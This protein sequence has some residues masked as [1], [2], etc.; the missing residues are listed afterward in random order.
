[1]FM[2]LKYYLIGMK[3]Y[4]FT[5]QIITNACAIQAILGELMNNSDK[6]DIG[7]YFKRIKIFY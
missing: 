4:F 1:M 2:H 3:I 7:E 5:K 6:I